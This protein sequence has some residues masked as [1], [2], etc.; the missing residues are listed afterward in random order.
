MINNMGKKSRRK[1]GV[2]K[3]GTLECTE[4]QRK[5]ISTESVCNNNWINSMA[6]VMTEGKEE[7]HSDI[8]LLNDSY[9]ASSAVLSKH[10]HLYTSMITLQ[11]DK[12]TP[13]VSKFTDHAQIKQLLIEARSNL[14]NDVLDIIIDMVGYRAVDE[15]ICPEK[16][17]KIVRV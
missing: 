17:D 2:V 12:S 14:P 16:K 8:P 3:H 15:S 4:V 5:S 7:W 13:I 11:T 9:T 10:L 1:K 6:T